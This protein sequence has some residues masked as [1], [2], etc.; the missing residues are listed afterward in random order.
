[1]ED[2]H[3]SFDV[4]V[5]VFFSDNVFVPIFIFAQALNT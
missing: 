5:C 1:M 2:L 3:D 4:C